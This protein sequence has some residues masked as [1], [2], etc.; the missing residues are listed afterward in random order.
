[1][2]QSPMGSVLPENYVW[3][4][5]TPFEILSQS[6]AAQRG[7]SMNVKRAGEQM[8]LIA[9]EQIMYTL[10]HS[11]GEYESMATRLLGKM[12]EF[13][14]LK[15]EGAA[16]GNALPEAA[17]RIGTGAA[18][19]IKG[20]YQETAE[21]TLG[22]MQRIQSGLAG[23]RVAN[24]K[25]DLPLVYEG[26][27]R[28]QLTLEF[29]LIGVQDIRKEVYEIVR[30]F[31]LYSAPVSKDNVY[32]NPP[33]VFNLRTEPGDII[34]ID[35]AALESVQPTWKSPYDEN[36]FPHA[37]QLTLTFRDMSPLYRRTL[38]QGGFVVTTAT[39]AG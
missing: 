7:A 28:R 20:N 15:S 24:T 35:K 27:E 10:G 2:L 21:Q 5:F 4:V 29:N 17:R 18:E 38:E 39:E 12:G 36:G 23:A 6:V 11:W 34:N 37:C 33:Y 30:N 1:M 31:E 32:L 8:K 13:A 14:K 19:A 3:I 22:A 26:S 16:L 9:P 25:V